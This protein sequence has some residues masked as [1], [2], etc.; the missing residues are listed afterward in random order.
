MTAERHGCGWRT[1]QRA[2]S[3]LLRCRQSPAGANLAEGCPAHPV[4]SSCPPGAV[5]RPHPASCS[6][7]QFL[8]IAGC[9]STAPTACRRRNECGNASGERLPGPL[10]I[11][12]LEALSH[13]CWRDQIG[14]SPPQHA[15]SASVSEGTRRFF[16][17]R[18]SRLT[19]ASA[20]GAGPAGCLAGRRRRR[21]RRRAVQERRWPRQTGS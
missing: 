14:R 21:W 5:R 3:E 6:S 9:L 17:A 18:A 20:P 8:S 4:E 1:T 15:S 2:G 11:H 10:Y 7:M 19:P 16:H 12:S 13:P